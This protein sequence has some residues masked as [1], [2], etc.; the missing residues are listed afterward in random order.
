MR[1]QRD[2]TRNGKPTT[3]II[4]AITSRPAAAADAEQLANFIRGH[5]SI[6]NRIHYVRDVTFREDASRVRTGNAPR[7]LAIMR[8][9]AIGVLRLAGVQNIAQG[10]RG[11]LFSLARV[12]Q[13]KS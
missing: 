10:L 7:T 6:E 4:Y 2:T 8:N 1:V 5:W 3:E 9:L 11:C 13:Q 12:P